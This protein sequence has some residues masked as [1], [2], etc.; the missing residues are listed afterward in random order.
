MAA[1]LQAGEEDRE[2]RE[3]GGGGVW[4]VVKLSGV[5]VCV[6]GDW[7]ICGELELSGGK[8]GEGGKS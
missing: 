7:V 1:A 2:K 3:E 5:C 6:G 8:S 4:R